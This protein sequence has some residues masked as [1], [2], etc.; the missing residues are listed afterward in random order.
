MALAKKKKRS[1][2]KDSLMNAPVPEKWEAA[3][4]YHYLLMGPGT[5]QPTSVLRKAGVALIVVPEYQD[6]MMLND[7]T[8]EY[9]ASAAIIVQLDNG[10]NV[11]YIYKVTVDNWR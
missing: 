9:E 3:V 8:N 6:N 5:H 7:L 11:E 1:V 4:L 2:A 10:D